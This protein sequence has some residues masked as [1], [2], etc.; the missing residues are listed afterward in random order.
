MLVM[1]KIMVN[2]LKRKKIL[3]KLVNNCY[4]DF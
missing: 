1:V 3:K 4:V 2:E